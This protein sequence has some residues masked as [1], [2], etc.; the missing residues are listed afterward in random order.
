M[1][2]VILGV[3]AITLAKVINVIDNPKRLSP[4]LTGCCQNP[5]SFSLKRFLINQRLAPGDARLAFRAP[6]VDIAYLPLR[7]DFLTKTF[8]IIA[9]TPQNS[10]E[11]S[12]RFP[13]QC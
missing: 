1:W 11:Y 3:G 2:L 5:F 8:S 4:I 13:W 6:A 7:R 12:L 9:L 10:N